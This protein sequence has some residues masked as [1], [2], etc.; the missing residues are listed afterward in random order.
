MQE[1]S[2][3]G[4]NLKKAPQ[5]EIKHYLLR[6]NMQNATILFSPKVDNQKLESESMVP[7]F[8]ITHLEYVIWHN[9]YSDMTRICDFVT[10]CKSRWRP[11]RKMTVTLNFC[12]AN[13][14]Y[15]KSNP[16]GVCVP[17][18]VLFFQGMNDCYCYLLNYQGACRIGLSR[19]N[20]IE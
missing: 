3:I 12:V 15:L 13:R 14:F 6:Q 18:L 10:Q 20:W 4:P 19:P 9:G 11:S 5:D 1:F 17:K 8:N 2:M 16:Q 7:N